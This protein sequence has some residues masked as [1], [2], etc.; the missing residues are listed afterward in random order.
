MSIAEKLTTVAE[1][2]QKVFDAGKQSEYDRFWDNYQQNGERINYSRAF[3]GTCWSDETYNPKYPIT[4]T[5]GGAYLFYGS[6][7]TDTKV[8]ID[9]GSSSSAATYRFY[10]AEK[11]VTIRKLIVK[12]GAGYTSCFI[13]CAALEN[14]TIEGVIGKNFDISDSPKLTHESLMSIID[15]LKDTKSTLTLTIGSENLAKLT[16]A[17]KAIATEKGWTLV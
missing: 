2:Q 9:I 3:G 5:E 15:H 7:I 6:L 16:D 13:G 1:N 14:I 10:N 8:D 17:E 12:E 4:A 11:L